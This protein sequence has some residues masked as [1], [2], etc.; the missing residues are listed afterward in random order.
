M[1]KIKIAELR[2][3]GS[4]YDNNSILACVDSKEDKTK[5]DLFRIKVNDLLPL[6]K[7]VN[8]EVEQKKVHKYIKIK[9][10]K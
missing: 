8:W 10:A 5:Y 4:G 7:G 2:T 6:L 9:E 3:L 1:V